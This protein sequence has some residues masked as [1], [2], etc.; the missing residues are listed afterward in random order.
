MNQAELEPGEML[1]SDNK[2]WLHNAQAA[3]IVNCVPRR[4]NSMPSSLASAD[5]IYITKFKESGY[6]TNDNVIDL[7]WEYNDSVNVVTLYHLDQCESQQEFE[8]KWEDLCR[9]LMIEIVER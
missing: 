7:V 2:I 5:E 8:D 6:G 3:E 4:F 1:L 9:D